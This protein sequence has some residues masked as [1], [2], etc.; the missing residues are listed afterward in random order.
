MIVQAASR[1]RGAAQSVGTRVL[2]SSDH[3]ALFSSAVLI[4]LLTLGVKGVTLLRDMTV[5]ARF[6]TTDAND[7]FVTAWVLPGFVAGMVTGGF[8]GALI[9]AAIDT[10]AKRGQKRQQELLGEI[11]TISTV[12]FLVLTAVMYGAHRFLLPLVA[13]G[14]SGEKL[15]LTVQISFIMLPAMAAGGLATIWSSML[16]ID[17][18]FGLVAMTPVLV[19]LT[20]TL[21][22]VLFPGAGIEWLAAGMV[23]GTGLQAMVLYLGLQRVGLPIQFGWHGLMPETRSMMSQVGVLALNG[24]IFGGL[25]VVDTAMAATLGPGSQSILAY[26]NKLIVPVMGISSVAIGTVILPYYSRLVANEDWDELRHTLY[27]YVKLILAIAIPVMLLIMVFS[28]PIVALLFER[29]EF[30]ADDSYHVARVLS[31]Y[32]LLVPIETIAVMMSRVLVSMQ[33]GKA[34]VIGSIGIFIFNIVADYVLKSF[35]GIE[36]IAFATVMNQALSL[37]FLIFMWRYLQRTRMKR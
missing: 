5:A 2:A 20:S 31:I 35:F 33:I 17:N 24:V 18:H 8:A 22:L 6:G 4:G 13:Q 30:T 26:A 25:G 19:P 28:R 14:Y 9:P 7:A 29:G 12:I 10:R 34:M 16:N 37:V 15:D 32:A 3:R 27:T 11:M 21:I 23:I 36:G 1:A